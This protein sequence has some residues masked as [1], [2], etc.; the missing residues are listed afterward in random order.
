MTGKK[1]FLLTALAL[2]L[3]LP[4]TACFGDGDGGG[5]GQ[6]VP[7]LPVGIFTVTARDTP[8]PAEFQARASGSRAV[9]VR[10][11]VQ[12]IIEKRLYEEGSF[13]KAGQLLF[14]IERDQ[15]EA[16]VQQAE[17]QLDSAAREWKRV[18]PLYEK[19]AV[20]QKERDNAR[21]AYD[22]ARAELRQARINLD[23]CQVVAP[24]SGYS[25][26]ENYTE[27]NL[28]SQNSLLTQV[29]QTDPMNIDFSIA[30]PNHMRRHQLTLAGRLRRPENNAYT[31]RLRLLDGSM[32]EGAGEVNFIDSQVQADTGVIKARASFANGRNEIMP[33]QYVRIYMDGDVL[34]D[35]MLIPQ[36]A[37]MV[38]QK[39]TFVM[40]VGEGNVVSQRA[41]KVSDSIGDSYLVDEGLKDGERIVST[42]L[43]KARPGSKVSELPAAK[44][45]EARPAGKEG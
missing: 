32:Y 14:Q 37:V 28:V 21:A 35:A 7:A 24:V 31:A 38:T 3:C 30:A 17:A 5:K 22:S 19:N 4:L 1:R 33:G 43:L 39:G 26:K 18:R 15:Y 29:N 23:Y 2:A 20:S 42:G 9:E 12:G 45:G 40:V 25:S 13:V 36:S 44:A 8:W 6:G 11:R 16:Q 41:V 27:G 34:T 10:A